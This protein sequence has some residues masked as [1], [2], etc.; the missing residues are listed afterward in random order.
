MEMTAQ[1][2]NGK[3]AH[4][5]IGQK[6]TYY[7]LQDGI[8]ETDKCLKQKKSFSKLRETNSLS[9]KFLRL[10][11]GYL[12]YGNLKCFVRQMLSETNLIENHAV[13]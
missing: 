3:Q 12:K 8:M 7:Q 1:L 4:V 2:E 10:N 11:F 5:E 6:S 9:F 13:I